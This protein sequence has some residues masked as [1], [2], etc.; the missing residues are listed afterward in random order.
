VGHWRRRWRPHP[1]V[2]GVLLLLGFLPP[3]WRVV[4]VD[5]RTGG[6]AGFY[7]CAISYPWSS[8]SSAPSSR[9]CPCVVAHPSAGF[10]WHPRPFPTFISLLSP[11]NTPVPMF[12]HNIIPPSTGL[13]LP[14]SALLGFPLARLAWL[15][16][17]SMLTVGRDFPCVIP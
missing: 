2:G 6:W 7:P 15:S 9:F 8:S 14:S 11:S 17:S 13:A 10:S 12:H 5:V 4:V 16:L 3:C 1:K